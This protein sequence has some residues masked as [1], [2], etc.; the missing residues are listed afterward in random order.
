MADDLSAF[1]SS[2]DAVDAW[3]AEL[4]GAIVGHVARHRR[5]S[6]E[7]MVLAAAAIRLDEADGWRRIG[8]V[9]LE[10]RK[11]GPLEEFVHLAADSGR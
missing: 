10:S 5:T 9:T 11:K 3:V 6:D 7:A 4:D 1:I 2:P 8:T